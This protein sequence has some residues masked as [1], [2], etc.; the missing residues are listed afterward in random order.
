MWFR[1]NISLEIS[2]GGNMDISREEKE[3][4][5][6]LYKGLR[7]SDVRDGMDWNM[8][9]HC[10]SMSPD[11]RPLFRTRV[12]GFARTARY[13][14]Y[15][16]PTPNMSSEAYTEWVDWYYRAICP[17]PWDEDIERDDFIVIDQCNVDCGLMGSMNSLAFYMLGARGYVIEGGVRDTDELI[18]Q[19]IPVWSRFVSQKMVQ[20]RLQFDAKNIPVCVGG[21]V[22]NPGDVIVADGDGVIVV[23]KNMAFDV[24][25]YARRELET[26]KLARK[27]FYEQLGW[28]LDLTVI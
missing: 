20:A 4:L 1:I 15:Q 23:P 5:L 14:P 13:I 11:I 18:Q 22:V 10:G 3:E 25:K 27:R 24:A 9:H 8:M 26:D 6:D 21:V 16:G 12:V 19:K 17:Y 2:E 7:V 28:E